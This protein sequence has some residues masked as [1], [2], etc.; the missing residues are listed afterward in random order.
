MLEIDQH[1]SFED[2]IRLC[3]SLPF[4]ERNKKENN[5]YWGIDGG[6][7]SN[8]L[9][10]W[11]NVFTKDEI[12]IIFFEKFKQNPNTVLTELCKWLDIESEE[13]ISSLDISVE[14]K[15]VKYKNKYLQIIAL[16]LNQKAEYLWRSHP[17]LKRALRKIYYAINGVPYRETIP[18]E[19]FRYLSNKYKPYNRELARL[20]CQR[21][22]GDLP[23]WVAKE[24]D[25]ET[26]YQLV[27]NEK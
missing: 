6:F 17:E 25:M 12:R 9:P 24:I 27:S 20:L 15:S 18:N 16:T 13:F 26:E 4:S 11:F 1:L 19:M 7:Y 2:Y 10:G 23:E 14:N 5:L 8:Y 3:E 21:G 22:I